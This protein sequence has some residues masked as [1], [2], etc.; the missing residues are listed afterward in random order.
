MQKIMRALGMLLILVVSTSL[1]VGQEA[2]TDASVNVSAQ[3]GG[4]T[5]DAPFIEKMFVLADD[6]LLT[7]GTQVMPIPGVGDE[8][9]YKDFDKYVIVSDPN[10]IADIVRVY[11]KLFYP[12]G[13]LVSSETTCTDITSNPEAYTAALD[14]ALE[15]G[16]ISSD[17]YEDYI[18]GLNDAKRQLKIFTVENSLSSCDPAGSY[19]VYFKV[20]D[21]Y[22]LYY[23]DR[24]NFDYLALKAIGLD[25]SEINYGSVTVNVEKWVSGDEDW[26]TPAKPTIKNEGNDPLQISVQGN[27][28]IG[29]NLQQTLSA[30]ALSVE[31]LGEH[32]YG[33]DQPVILE[34][35]LQPC[36]PT[37]I[38]FDIKPPLGT[39][40]DT[41]RGT[42]VIK[43]AADGS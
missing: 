5:G 4:T 18:Y 20:V 22:G 38:S 15:A 1:A 43:I 33:L 34:G 37:Q 12:D 7:N 36:T 27:E 2:Q 11:E 9:S 28:M 42:V 40:A 32:V 23:E 41:Y 8:K 35:F 25:F 3:V 10:G 31:L 30:D 16:L 6:D 21:N 17:E 26:E 19:E 24:T 13:T 29:D 14:D 39:A